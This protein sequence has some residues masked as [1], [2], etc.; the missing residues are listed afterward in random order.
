M[1]AG[2]TLD[3]V[4]V[5]SPPSQHAADVLASL[6]AGKHVLCE[7][8]MALM[9]SQ[10]V[11]MAKAASQTQVVCGIVHEYRFSPERQRLKACI[12]DD[13]VGALRNIEITSLTTRRRRDAPVRRGW[14]CERERG[15]GVAG[16]MLSHLVDE[17]NWLAGRE[18]QHSTGFVRTAN[19]WRR[20]DQGAFTC[21]ADD[22]AFALIDYGQGLVARVSADATTGICF[23]VSAVHGEKASVIARGSD[24]ADLALQAFEGGGAFE[25]GTTGERPC[26]RHGEERRQAL[27]VRLYD[28]FV[29]QVEMGSSALP[30][31]SE[32]LATQRVLEA[33]GFSGG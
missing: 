3:V 28:E 2:C 7:K 22:G 26:V 19:S 9:L 17:A 10:A 32:G 5:A 4:L 6:G 8:P 16:S 23:H 12:E 30:S 24:I 31:F 14:K 15:G 21:S 18:P 20:D 33:I 1:L 11:S 29:R 25:G 27:L 13:T